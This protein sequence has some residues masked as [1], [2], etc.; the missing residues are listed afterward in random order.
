MKKTKKTS[1]H[2]KRVKFTPLEGKTTPITPS[3]LPPFASIWG[4]LLPDR[5]KHVKNAFIGGSGDRAESLDVFNKLIDLK[6]NL[7]VN[8]EYH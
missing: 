5:V 7:F 6:L 8:N 2:R 1:P 4:I 3:D